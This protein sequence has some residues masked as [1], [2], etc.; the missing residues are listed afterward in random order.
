MTVEQGRRTHDHDG[1]L[2]VFLI[3]MTLNRP[4]R[5]DVWMPAFMSMPRMLEELTRDEDCRIHTQLPRLKSICQSRQGGRQGS[6]RDRE[7][8]RD[9]ARNQQAGTGRAIGYLRQCGN[10]CDRCRVAQALCRPGIGA[11]W[12]GN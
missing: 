4:W 12:S 10:R 5:A 7:V 3:G 9:G 2:V 1:E 6:A 11:Q 8:G